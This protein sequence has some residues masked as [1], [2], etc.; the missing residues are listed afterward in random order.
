MVGRHPRCNEQEFGRTLG[1]GEGQQD[2]AW[3]SPWG[4][5]ELD[6]TGQLNNNGNNICKS[7]GKAHAEISMLT[8]DIS[9]EKC[10][11]DRDREREIGWK[12][13]GSPGGH[14]GKPRSVWP[15][16]NVMVIPCNFYY[17][18]MVIPCNFYYFFK[19][20]FCLAD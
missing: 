18:V 9:I 2:L 14:G 13:P 3:C 4:R 12:R 15:G 8:E 7:D 5:K 19:T 1:D 6:M 10:G 11:Q 16:D 17:N 20:D